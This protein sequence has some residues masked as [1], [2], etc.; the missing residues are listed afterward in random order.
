MPDSSV[1]KLPVLDLVSD[2]T[3]AVIAKSA[4][5]APDAYVTGQTPAALRAAYRAERVY[6]NEGGPAM[7]ATLDATV[8]TADGDVPVRVH[9]PVDADV[10]PAVL[11]FHGGGFVV[12]DLDTHS[13][14]MRMLAAESGAAVVGVDYSLS[15]EA[16]F[17]VAL[18]QCAA[19]ARHVA[20]HGRDWGLDGARIAFAGDSGGALLAL[21]AWLYLSDGAPHEL[22]DGAPYETSG[23]APSRPDTSRG[24]QEPPSPQAP[25]PPESRRGDA[26]A[27]V[28][29]LALYYGMFGLRDA[30]SRRLLGG[31]WDG[32]T[33]EDLDYYM[34]AYL[35]DPAEV[36]SP[37]VDCLAADLSG[38]PPAY[39]AA[40]EFDPVLDDSR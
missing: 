34:A 21:G 30:P 33:Q 17:P 31:P 10:L 39:I 24:P 15:P 18:R 11:Y 19:V 25:A 37:Y 8:A 23:L 9:S 29:A 2:Q 7:A 14:I 12:G 22:S 3:R 1:N 16:K 32:V 28:K 27:S 4:E 13:R 6:W 5:L 35:A 20:A 40:A 26:V 38:L 36:R